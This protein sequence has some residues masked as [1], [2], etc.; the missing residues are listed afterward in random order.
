MKAATRNYSASSVDVIVPCYKYGHFLRQCVESVLMQ[1]VTVRVLVIDDA[2]PD[3]TS[4]VASDLASKDSRVTFVRHSVNRGHIA[5]YNEGIEWTSSDYLLLLS[6]DDYL[7]PGALGHAATIMDVNPD[8]GFTFGK[9]L[10]QSDTGTIQNANIGT[11]MMAWRI[12]TGGEFIELSGSRNIVPTPTAVVRTELQKRVGGYRSELP[13]SGDLEMWLRLAAHGSVGMLE[14]YQAVYRL[15]ASNMSHG[16]NMNWWPDLQQRQAAFDWFFRT[17]SHAL[18]NP[19]QFRRRML[20]L[21]SC[22]ALTLAS[23]A[24][25]EG[26]MD[27]SQQLSEYAV[28]LCPEAK[29]SLPWMKL[30]CKRFMG[31][32]VWR[33]LRPTV[34]GIRQVASPFKRLAKSASRRTWPIPQLKRSLPARVGPIG[35]IQRSRSE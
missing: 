21:F 20:W 25:N 26:K 34:K 1:P 19:Q 17:C 6:A 8:V 35:S 5:T 4:E 14:T 27:V 7:L 11:G 12:L 22:D 9:A 16:Y 3:N 23:S 2:S 29:G 32:S 18:S 10:T 24:F 33:A 31:Y 30:T 15:H 13:H 28:S